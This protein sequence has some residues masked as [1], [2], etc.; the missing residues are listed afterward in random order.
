MEEPMEPA[1]VAVGDQPAGEYVRFASDSGAATWGRVEGDEIVALHA[2]PWAGGAPTGE[3]VA[4][5]GASLL[6]PADPA[7]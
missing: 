5:A 4:R 1:A 6:A 7:R 3:R 2:A